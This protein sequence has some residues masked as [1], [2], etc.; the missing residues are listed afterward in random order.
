MTEGLR[1]EGEE[2]F[3]DGFF[4]RASSVLRTVSGTE[5]GAW[6]QAAGRTAFPL[7]TP[8]LWHVQSTAV[9]VYKMGQG[10]AW[11]LDTSFPTF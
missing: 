6:V 5:P 2:G 8:A 11:V 7:Q 9:G 1:E 4:T 10:E 3:G